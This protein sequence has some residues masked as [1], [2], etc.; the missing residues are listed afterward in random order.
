MNIPFDLQ[1]KL[2]NSYLKIKKNV[3]TTQ[4]F[5][6]CYTST[7]HFDGNVLNEILYIVCFPFNSVQMIK[8]LDNSSFLK[9]RMFHVTELTRIQPQIYGFKMPIVPACDVFIL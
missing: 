2:N 9:L 8:I 4:M 6:D 5:Q 1:C 7:H 3:W